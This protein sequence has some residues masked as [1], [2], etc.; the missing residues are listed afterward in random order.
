MND[1]NFMIGFDYNSNGI[2]HHITEEEQV[3]LY[4]YYTIQ[5]GIDASD[6]GDHLELLRNMS[7]TDTTTTTKTTSITATNS[8]GF[9]TFLP[10]PIPTVLPKI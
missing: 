8:T 5:D 7:N 10:T 9:F 6:P 2:L 4:K 1:F 3:N